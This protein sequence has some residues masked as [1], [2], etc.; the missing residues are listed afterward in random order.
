MT[1]TL[2][3]AKPRVRVASQ[4]PSPSGFPPIDEYRLLDEIEAP[5]GTDRTTLS[6][7]LAEHVARLD[8]DY[9]IIGG[10]GLGCGDVYVTQPEDEPVRIRFSLF[11]VRA[12][13]R[14]LLNRLAK[15]IELRQRLE[16]DLESLPVKDLPEDR[17]GEEEFSRLIADAPRDFSDVF[18]RIEAMKRK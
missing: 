18:A 6:R 10:G 9:R 3:I 13:E 4:L 11:P 2:Q 1:A 16:P 7:R 8:A 17:I 5:T 14:K 15:I 12:G